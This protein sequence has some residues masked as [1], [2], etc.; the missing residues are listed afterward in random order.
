[1][2]KI[3]R[4]W[5][6]NFADT[7]TTGDVEMAEFSVLLIFSS[8]LQKYQPP[9]EDRGVERTGILNKVMRISE[10]SKMRVYC[11][12]GLILQFSPEVS[13]EPQSGN[14]RPGRA[15][16]MVCGQFGQLVRPSRTRTGGDWRRGR[17]VPGRARPGVRV[18]E[19]LRSM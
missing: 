6:F 16:L 4:D 18:N 3:R 7:N 10:F 2:G 17:R 5:I 11:L 12:L 8:Y 1:M 19:I 15:V 9:G 14:P 13:T